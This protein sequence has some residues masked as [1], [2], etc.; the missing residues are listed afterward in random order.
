[1]GHMRP[2]TCFHSDSDGHAPAK[3]DTS[4]NFQ[5]RT[6]HMQRRTQQQGFTLAEVII[7]V[8]IIGILAAIAIPNF[9]SWLPNMRLKAAAR[10]LHSDMQRA[11]MEAVKRNTNVVILFNAVA[12][13]GLP[14][15]VP[16]PGG[17]YQIFVDDGA[18]GGTVKNNIRDGS[19]VILS[20][21]TMP[22]DT[23]LCAEN[24]GGNTGFTPKGL[25]IGNNIGTVTMDNRTNRSYSMT[26]TIAGGIRWQ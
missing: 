23:A 2:D 6:G 12:C 14:A 19:E 20:T 24:F 4:K 10:D 13:P 26:L 5:R 1:M 9:L 22:I 7:V 11:K 21:V 25:L 15:A 17:G 16:T 3:P 8:A 18:G